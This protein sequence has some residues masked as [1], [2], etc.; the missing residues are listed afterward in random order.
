[1][2][3]VRSMSIPKRPTTTG[4]MIS[5]GQYPIPKCSSISHATS[6]PSMYRAPWQKL[7]TF[8]SPKMIARPRLSSA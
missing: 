5:A 7:M 8:S 1:L 4:E 6:A 3:I 2:I